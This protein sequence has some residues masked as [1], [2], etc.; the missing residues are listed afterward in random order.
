MNLKVWLSFVTND[1]LVDL[2][3]SAMNGNPCQIC[4]FNNKTKEIDIMATCK[5]SEIHSTL[6]DRH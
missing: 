3:K 6:Q 1:V 2:M 4:F 5:A